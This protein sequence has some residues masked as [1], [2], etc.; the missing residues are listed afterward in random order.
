MTLSDLR[1]FRGQRIII[2]KHRLELCHRQ[3]AT[4]DRGTPSLWSIGIAQKALN[5]SIYQTMH[6]IPLWQSQSTMRRSRLTTREQIDFLILLQKV[7]NAS[8]A[9]A[10][11]L[12]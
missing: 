1:S 11:W 6:G 3:I 5:S 4:F 2:A 10:A 12:Q 8:C 7:Q 9:F